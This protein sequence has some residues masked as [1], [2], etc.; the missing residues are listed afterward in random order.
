MATC[1]EE[2]DA[3]KIRLVNPK[4]RNDKLTVINHTEDTSVTCSAIE[5]YRLL[6]DWIDKGKSGHTIHIVDLKKVKEKKLAPGT[7]T[8]FTVDCGTNELYRQVAG[9]WER[10]LAQVKNLSIAR[11]MVAEDLFESL[12]G[13]TTTKI[14][15]RMFEGEGELPDWMQD[16]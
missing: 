2:R 13:L 16:H 5:A 4:T 3:L 6:N 12:K 1:I 7:Q 9:E 10:I 11:H 15:K 8:K 14:A